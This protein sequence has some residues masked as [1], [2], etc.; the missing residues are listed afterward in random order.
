MISFMPEIYADELVYSWFCRYYIHS[1]ALCHRAALLELFEK[2]SC[3]P[4]KE[5]IGYLN[6]DARRTIAE[7]IPI[8]RL[9][10]DHTMFPQYARFIP[11]DKKITALRQL[12]EG[13]TDPHHLMTILIRNQSSEWLRYCP[14]CASED[15]EK[16]GEAYWHRIHQIRNINVCPKHHCTLVN[17]PVSIKSLYTFAFTPAELYVTEMEAEFS[18]N[19][20]EID[21]ANY[22][23]ELVA[24]PMV[25]KKTPPISAVIYKAM[26]NTKY[27][28]STGRS[29]YTKQ[30]Y[31]DITD[32]YKDIPLQNRITFAQIQRALLGSLAEFTTITQIAFFLGIKTNEILNSNLTEAEISAERDSHYMRAAG[33]VDWHRLDSDTSPILEKLAYD[34]YHGT[35]GRPDRVSE[36]FICKKLGLLGHQIENMPMCQ[37]IF[38]QYAEPYASAWARRII[39]AYD[40]LASERNGRPFY[41]SDIRLLAGV[42]KA[43]IAKIMPFL[44]KFT[45]PEKTAAIIELINNK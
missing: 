30:F 1:G 23:A 33:P 25:F 15:R 36:K 43:N 24:A 40:K 21:F 14:L 4:N 9:V 37:K 42:K 16:Y 19:Q 45:T 20:L 34:I 2:K 11:L 13:S 26:K 18:C 39:W 35:H 44:S 7:I 22:C 12:G 10:L 32:F 5:F 38:K 31:E 41:W 27:L 3:T 8:N 28:K 17:S 6:A 29:R